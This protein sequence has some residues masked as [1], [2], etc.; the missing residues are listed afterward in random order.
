MSED[1]PMLRLK[2]MISARKFRVGAGFTIAVP[3]S[4]NSDGV[5]VNTDNIKPGFGFSFRTSYDLANRLTLF[6]NGTRISRDLDGL[7]YV[8]ETSSE[9]VPG[10]E[11]KVTYYYKIGVL[12]NFK[13]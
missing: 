8:S 2:K 13:N 6:A 9:P 12:W 10:N 5:G 4:V 11:H 3:L 7:G 1:N